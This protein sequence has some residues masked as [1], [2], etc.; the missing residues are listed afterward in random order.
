[1]LGLGRKLEVARFGWMR[2]TDRTLH[3]GIM[4][5]RSVATL[6]GGEVER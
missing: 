3:E 2:Q 1:M 6:S 5:H 4:Q